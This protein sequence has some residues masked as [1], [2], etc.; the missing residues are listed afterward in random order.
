MFEINVHV[1]KFCLY[2]LTEK[3][4]ETSLKNHYTV[5]DLEDYDIVFPHFDKMQIAVKYGN[6][7]NKQG[8]ESMVHEQDCRLLAYHIL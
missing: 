5:W 7:A 6:V 2:S 3:K 8:A 4:E 1:Q